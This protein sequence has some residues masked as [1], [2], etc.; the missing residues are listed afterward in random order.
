[1]HVLEIG[2]GHGR[3]TK[4]YVGSVGK[5][6]LVDLSPS[7]IEHCKK[8]FSSLNHIDYFVNDGSTLRPLGDQ[9]IDFI[10]SYD[11]FVHIE[12]PEFKRYLLEGAR[13]LKPGGVA[14]IHH[15][16]SELSLRFLTK[17]FLIN[18][19][20]PLRFMMANYIFGRY[21]NMGQSL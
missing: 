5:V 9:T 3:W 16:N 11:V 12:R 19:T 7:C 15:P 20:G 10:W 8:L 2:P 13:V 21:G 17:L 6:T 18:M 14:V 4:L 1:M